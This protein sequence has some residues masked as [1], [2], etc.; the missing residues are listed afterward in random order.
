MSHGGAMS[1]MI[2][3]MVLVILLLGKKLLVVRLNKFI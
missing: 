1:T 3:F 2:V